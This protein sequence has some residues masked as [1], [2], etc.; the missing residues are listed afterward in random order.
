MVAAIAGPIVQRSIQAE[1]LAQADREMKKIAFEL[2]EVKS[3]PL[4]TT[5]RG[6]ASD[7]GLSALD[8]WGNPYQAKLLRNP[9]GIPTH[10]VIWS[11]GPNGRPDTA[12]VE[13]GARIG[14]MAVVFDG[15]DI[16]YITSIR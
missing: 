12:S 11:G 6:P 2:A 9:Y 10:L 14:A 3:S 5:D 8:P 4:T 7:Q 16:G 1:N 13:S 15:D